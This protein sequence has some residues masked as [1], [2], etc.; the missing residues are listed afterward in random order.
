MLYYSFIG[1][2]PYQ[3]VDSVYILTDQELVCSYRFSHD[4]YDLGNFL[5]DAE[6]RGLRSMNRYD[7]YE[8]IQKQEA[9]K[10]YQTSKKLIKHLL[11]TNKKR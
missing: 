9:L 7:A 11:K 2:Y 3:N 1:N 4:S 5:H 6:N 10:K 8:V